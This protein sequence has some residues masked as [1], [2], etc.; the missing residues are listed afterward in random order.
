V[1]WSSAPGPLTGGCSNATTA[2]EGTQPFVM[3]VPP[4]ARL[5]PRVRPDHTIGYAGRA[6]FPSPLRD[7][8]KAAGESGICGFMCRPICQPRRPVWID[9]RQSPGVLRWILCWHPAFVLIRGPVMQIPET[10]L[11]DRAQSLWL[12]YCPYCDYPPRVMTM[13]SIRP[14][15]CRGQ[16]RITYEC[17]NCGYEKVC[18]LKGALSYR[19]CR[20][21]HQAIDSADGLHRLWRGGEC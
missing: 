11:A 3:A 6:A 7:S 8:R 15:M 14:A 13:K 18:V 4:R 21:R 1:V 19:S 20:H 2:I 12:Q 9:A 5:M 10:S 16:D 17:R